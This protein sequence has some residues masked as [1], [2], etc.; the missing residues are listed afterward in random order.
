MILQC[1]FGTASLCALALGG[2]CC[3]LFIASPWI[4]KCY[5]D[6]IEFCNTWMPWKQARIDCKDILG[7]S[8][9]WQGRGADSHCD[10]VLQLT[11]KIATEITRTGACRRVVNNIAY[12]DMSLSSVTPQEIVNQ[13]SRKK[14]S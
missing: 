4:V 6:H 11:T 13:I 12:I 10:L 8:S 2:Y 9:N 14:N 3:Y 1:F 5:K 7:A